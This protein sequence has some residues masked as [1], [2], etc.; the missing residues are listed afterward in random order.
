MARQIYIRRYPLVKCSARFSTICRNLLLTTACYSAKYLLRNFRSPAHVSGP[1]PTKRREAADRGC[2]ERAEGGCKDLVDR[3]PVRIRLSGSSCRTLLS[4]CIC[5]RFRTFLPFR[6]RF[7]ANGKRVAKTTRIY[8][9]AFR[10]S[11]SPATRPFE[12]RQER[13]FPNP[14]VNP[15][16]SLQK[17]PQTK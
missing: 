13:L 5:D 7:P 16:M 4:C 3:L 10:L 6:E 1:Y 8:A 2:R 17:P 15:L 12:D 14:S 9:D 11:C